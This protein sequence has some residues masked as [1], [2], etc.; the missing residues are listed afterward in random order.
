[1]NPSG[2]ACRAE[3][4]PHPFDVDRQRAGGRP[5]GS[6]RGRRAHR[7]VGRGEPASGRECG[8]GGG[9]LGPRGPPGQHPPAHLRRRERRSVLL[10]RRAEDHL[11]VHPRRRAVRPDLHDEPGWLGPAD[12]EHQR[13]AHYL[14]LLLSGG[15]LGHLRLD[16]PGRRR[17]PARAELPDG[18]RVGHLRQLRH[19]PRE[20]GRQR[21]D[22][23]D[24]RAGLRRRGDHRAEWPRRLHQRARRRHGDLLHERRWHGRAPADPT[25]RGRTAGRSS[26]RTARRSSSA[27]GR[28]PTVRSTTTSSGSST[29]GCGGPPRSRSSSWTPTAATCGR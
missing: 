26:R 16:A 6:A 23:A 25:G 8:A 10:V 13:R 19:L 21:A 5:G 18:L 7:R 11:P 24:R 29:R 3:P 27:A 17:V 2:R 28:S 1:M 14:W 15:R 12:G 9:G 22:P 4:F 20:P